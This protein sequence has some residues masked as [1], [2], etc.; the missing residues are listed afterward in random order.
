[1]KNESLISDVKINLS[2][3]GVVVSNL[4]TNILLLANLSK[5]YK[6]VNRKKENEVM[7]PY[8]ALM[9]LLSYHPELMD[10]PVIMQDNEVIT[11]R[12]FWNSIENLANFFEHVCGLNKGENI[13]ICSETSIEGM[14][15]FFG[16]NAMG[17]VNARVFNGSKATKFKRDLEI[18]D[19]K[20]VIVDENNL[21]TLNEFAGETKIE[22]V[23]V[24]PPCSEDIIQEFRTKYPGIDIYSWGNVQRIGKSLPEHTYVE[25]YENDPASIL[26]TSGSSGENKKILTP[27]RC[28]TK[29]VDI[30]K[31]TTSEHVA[32]GE[33]VV[34]VVSPEYPYAANNSTTMII[35]LGKVLILPKR[36]SE[37]DFNDIFDKGIN[38]I[39]AIPLLYKLLTGTLES[40][41]ISEEKK[42]ELIN[43]LE[44]I[45]YT[46]SGGEPYQ[47]AEKK[48]FLKIMA[49][50]GYVPFLIDGFGFGELGSATALKFGLGDYFLLMN[51]IEAKT[52]DP[53]TG[54][55]LP[56]GQEGYICLTGPTI[57]DGYFGNEEQTKKSFIQDKDGKTWFLSDTYGTVKGIGNRLIHLG[58]RDRECYITKVNGNFIKV[59]AGNIEN[60]LLST[61][62]I[63]DCIIVPTG[64]E[65]AKPSAYISLTENCNLSK[66]EIEIILREK[67]SMLE[68]FSQPVKYEFEDKIKRTAADKKD[69]TYYRNMEIEK[70]K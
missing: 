35:L 33:K 30:V 41:A 57:T 50:Y 24:I 66:E 48:H 3:N 2:K 39:Q 67:C 52:V 10:T 18:F 49:K 61:D 68:D 6:I 46:V 21:N 8:F 20:V 4:I 25:V 53:K 15:S 26:Y 58:G 43:S 19:S 34:G 36:G 12:E 70:A 1:M 54:E 5:H 7:S 42:Q 56:K 65:V 63:E 13:A 51:G 22:R 62:I 16:M 37:L 29:M 14:I 60:I 17:L 40:D 44:S 38:K 9:K 31:E 27:N 64:D 32:D 69:Y 11:Y 47:K 59:Y 45:D 55:D 28:F 23:I